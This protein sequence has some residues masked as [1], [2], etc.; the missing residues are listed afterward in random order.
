MRNIRWRKIRRG[1]CDQYFVARLRQA[2]S[3]QR[4]WRDGDALLRYS[5]TGAQYLDAA[6]RQDARAVQLNQPRQRRCPADREHVSLLCVE[7]DIDR[8]PAAA[9]LCQIAGD[10]RQVELRWSHH[11]DQ[12][13][14]VQIGLDKAAG[15]EDAG[16]A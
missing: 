7:I 8:Q 9:A 13:G 5:A 4:R 11:R 14:I 16:T 15:I 6:L 2:V 10:L 3:E 12:P 1:G